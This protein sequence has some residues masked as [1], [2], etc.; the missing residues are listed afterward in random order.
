MKIK[1]FLKFQIKQII[2]F[3]KMEISTLLY[4]SDRYNGVTVDENSLPSSPETFEKLLKMSLAQWKAE[5]KRGL[6][7]KIPINLSS[8]IPVAVNEGK[9][10][11]FF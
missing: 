9:Q 2:F 7:L 6:W 11:L 1:N 10:I 3:H 8:L 5:K 4:K